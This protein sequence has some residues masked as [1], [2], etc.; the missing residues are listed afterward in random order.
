MSGQKLLR[1]RCQSAHQPFDVL[2]RTTSAGR[3][4]VRRKRCFS[5]S[6]IQ[7]FLEEKVADKGHFSNGNQQRSFDMTGQNANF[8]IQAQCFIQLCALGNQQIRR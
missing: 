6:V 1:A 7:R 5:R 3:L 4:L 2:P 8:C